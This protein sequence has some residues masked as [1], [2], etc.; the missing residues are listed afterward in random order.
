MPSCCETNRTHRGDSIRSNPTDAIQ[1]LRRAVD[2]GLQQFR[3]SRATCQAGTLS[4]PECEQVRSASLLRGECQDTHRASLH[5]IWQYPGAFGSRPCAPNDPSPPKFD[6]A[7]VSLCDERPPSGPWMIGYS[8]PRAS[9]TR[10][11]F[12]AFAIMHLAQQR[13]GECR[14]AP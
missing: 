8:I 1:P 11:W 13:K 5:W 2:Q 6:T 3:D 12:H 4:G 7:E 9:E 14:L 10:V